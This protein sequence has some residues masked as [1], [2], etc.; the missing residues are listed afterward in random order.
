MALKEL[1]FKRRELQRA[2]DALNAKDHILTAAI[3]ESA[4]KIREMQRLD[5]GDDMGIDDIMQGQGNGM[6][7]FTNDL[8]EIRVKL[9][10]LYVYELFYTYH[11]E[12]ANIVNRLCPN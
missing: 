7:N 3:L 10:F 9:R 12:Y 11:D 5:G 6:E 1:E 8:N 2:E 4:I